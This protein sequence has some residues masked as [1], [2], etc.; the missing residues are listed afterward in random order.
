LQLGSLN[1]S[2][3]VTPPAGGDPK[4]RKAST[5]SDNVTNGR[6]GRGNGK[7]YTLDRLKRERPDLFARVV[8]K[9]LSANKAAIEAGSVSQLQ[10]CAGPPMDSLPSRKGRRRAAREAWV[11]SPDRRIP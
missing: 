5:N 9:E 6:D 7:A 8:A 11:G 2:V 3:R 10:S 4:T 1:A